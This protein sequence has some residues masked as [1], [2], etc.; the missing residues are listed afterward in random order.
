MDWERMYDRTLTAV[1]RTFQYSAWGA[2]IALFWGALIA[3]VVL[4]FVD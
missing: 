3:V 4:T 1:G 2:L